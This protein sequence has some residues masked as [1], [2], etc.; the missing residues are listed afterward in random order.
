M[1]S[2]EPSLAS[3]CT[4]FIF[5]RVFSSLLFSVDSTMIQPYFTPEFLGK[6]FSFVLVCGKRSFLRCFSTF[7]RVFLS[8]NNVCFTCAVLALSQFCCF[9]FMSNLAL[10]SSVKEVTPSPDRKMIKLLTFDI[11]FPP[12]RHSR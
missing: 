5:I 6:I 11:F 3:L 8:R 9:F 12:L 7:L 2:F 10:L 4:F 1:S